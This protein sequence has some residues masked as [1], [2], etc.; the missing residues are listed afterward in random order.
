[1]KKMKYKIA[2]AHIFLKSFSFLVLDK[3]LSHR[4]FSLL[5]AYLINIY[6]LSPVVDLR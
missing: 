1:M 3:N 2:S 4:E 6:V 5:N